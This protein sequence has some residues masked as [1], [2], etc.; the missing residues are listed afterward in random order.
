MKYEVVTILKDNRPRFLITVDT[1]RV[2][3]LASKYLKHMDQLNASP[4]TVRSA[5]F[6]LSYYYN[7][8]KQEEMDISEVPTLSYSEQSKHFVDFLYWVKLEITLIGNHI[9]VI[10]HAICI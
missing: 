10:K 8:L 4:N 2:E 5:A 3:M 6:A 1:V 7:F 9:R